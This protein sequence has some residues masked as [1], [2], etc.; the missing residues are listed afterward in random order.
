MD[1]PK[2][3]KPASAMKCRTTAYDSLFYSCRTCGWSA[4]VLQRIKE[5][6]RKKHMISNP[7]IE[8][9]GPSFKKVKSNDC[10]ILQEGSSSSSV[11][12][13][14]IYCI[15]MLK[16]KH[17]IVDHIRVV[18]KFTT[19]ESLLAI[20][21][22]SSSGDQ[23]VNCSRSVS[24]QKTTFQPPLPLLKN[25]EKVSNPVKSKLCDS[26]SKVDL[27]PQVCEQVSN[28]NDGKGK[29]RQPIKSRKVNYFKELRNFV[30][31]GALLDKSTSSESSTQSDAAYKS[32]PSD[33]TAAGMALVQ[34]DSNCIDSNSK[35]KAHQKRG[36]RP[37]T[38]SKIVGKVGR[39]S[40]GVKDCIPCSVKE[41][42]GICQ[43]CLHKK[44]M[45]YVLIFKQSDK[46]CES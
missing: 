10:E 40:C 31:S 22:D 18:H 19:Q 1:S 26:S 32:V 12:Y 45:K 20:T 24:S 35:S 44:I 7:S 41:N 6:I 14:C 43:P 36:R 39:F 37:K 23:D 42:C 46:S 21:N 34:N 2:L 33:A 13:K 25:T 27:P 17:E 4:T 9:Y 11:M 29:V 28:R 3:K 38:F 8:N 5:H 16:T 30:T 15:S